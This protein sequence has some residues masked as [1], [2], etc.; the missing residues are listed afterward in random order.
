MNV[1][2]I[3]IILVLLAFVIV[4]WCVKKSSMVS[5]DSFSMKKGKLGWFNIAAGIS[6]TYAGGAA[7]LTTAS[8]GYNFKWYA[9]VDPISLMLGIIIVLF[10]YKKYE[11]DKGVTIADLFSSNDKSLS[12][13][14]GIVTSFTFVLIVAANFVALSKLLSPFFPNIHPLIITFVVS[15]LIFSYVFLGGFNSVT[16]TDVLQ[17]IFIMV[18]LVLPIVIFAIFQHEQTECVETVHEFAVMPI[19]YIILFAIPIVFT[20]L[21][22]DINIRIKSAKSRKQGVLG[23]IA[24]GFFYF[25]IAASA[26][27]VGV[28]L[29]KHD[30]E[31]VDAEQAIPVFFKDNFS[32]ISVVAVIA[33]LA[34]IV[35]TLDSYVLNSII[36][37]SNDI[38]KPISRKLNVS[39]SLKIASVITYVLAMSIALFFNKI[40]VLSL[41]SL[42][43]YI[44]VLVPV[45][46]G[47]SIHLTGRQI[48]FGSIVN[49][50]LIVLFEIFSFSIGPKAVAYPVNGCAIMLLLLLFKSLNHIKK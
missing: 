21:S 23:V 47:K 35:S 15:T 50:L 37:I 1:S 45:I 13:L 8:I 28:Y 25:C 29:G 33:S 14:I 30:V 6:M 34:A 27:F 5:Y 39:K 38:M 49:I 24:G 20:P 43:I 4:G 26:A 3:I 11:S 9:L 12:I 2:Q 10:L 36:S 48:F 17:L 40:L 44:S 16:R 41:T 31:L 32:A 46:L 19:D 18:L 42:L 22:Q 7:I